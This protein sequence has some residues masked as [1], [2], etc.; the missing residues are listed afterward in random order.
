VTRDEWIA[1]FAARIGAKP[2]TAADVD[3]ILKLAATAAHTSERTAAPVAC[4]LAATTGRPL[5]ELN[6][7]ADG[8][9]SDAGS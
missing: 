1:S 9:G 6:R 4:W 8:V 3:E 5:A 2:P 7:I